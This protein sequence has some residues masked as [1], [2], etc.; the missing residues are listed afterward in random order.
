MSASSSS[1]ALH[2]PTRFDDKLDRPVKLG[3]DSILPRL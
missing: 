1:H 3:I 2:L